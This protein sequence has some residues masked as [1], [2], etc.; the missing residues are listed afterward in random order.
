[1]RKRRRRS[2]DMG[3]FIPLLLLLVITVSVF[4]WTIGA[5]SVIALLPTVV[6]GFTIT[7]RLAEYRLQTVGFCNLAGVLP[8]AGQLLDDSSR[9]N[10]IVVNPVSWAIMFGASGIGYLLLYMG[11]LVASML[12]QAFA[13]DRLRQINQERKR[14]VEEWGPDV[15]E[16]RPKP[17]LKDAG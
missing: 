3:G 11:P 2:G 1:M 5:L 4:E 10:E 6:L 9:F 7:G 8:Y 15:L 16:Y 17:G 13:Q 12:I 14:A